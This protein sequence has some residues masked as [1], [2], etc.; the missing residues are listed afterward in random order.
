MIKTV[1]FD[2]DGTLLDTLKDLAFCTNYTLKKYG[3]PEHPIDEYKYFVGNGMQKLIE[4]AL[5]EHCN[6]ENFVQKFKSDFLNYY[7]LHK[8]DHTK[9]YKG[10]PELL[11]NLQENNYKIAIASNKI[12]LATQ[13]LVKKY[14]PEII[15]AKILGQR[16]GTLPKP[17]PKIINEIIESTKSSVSESVLIGDTSID[18]FTSKNANIKSIGVLWGF[19]N[20]EELLNAGADFI[21]K[22]PE[23]IL[24]ILNKIT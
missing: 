17:N 3:F 1:I 20:A 19:R 5:P 9:P 13:E 24:K 15:F 10:I 22:K 4:R 12:N 16:D 14:F 7:S 8:E 18:I 6:N 23:D 21:A 2:L 11:K